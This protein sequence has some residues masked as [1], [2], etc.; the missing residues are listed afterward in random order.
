[1]K[2]LIAVVLLVVVVVSAGHSVFGNLFHK[3][4]NMIERQDF[5]G[6]ITE[7]IAY[8]YWTPIAKEKCE[9]GLDGSCNRHG[10]RSE[11]TSQWDDSTPTEKKAMIGTIVFNFILL[12]I[13]WELW[14]RQ[15]FSE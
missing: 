5:K 11:C 8:C 9:Y 10:S 4:R 13:A 1:M 2:K 15:K 3:T 12:L 14:L 6:N 7:Y